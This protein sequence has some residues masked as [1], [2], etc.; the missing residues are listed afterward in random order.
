MLV[1]K[2][3]GGAGIDHE[4]VFRNV[5]WLEAPAIDMSVG[6]VASPTPAADPMRQR[7]ICP[8]AQ[9]QPLINCASQSFSRHRWTHAS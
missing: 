6:E 7:Q 4:A 2:I 3:G 1:I 8:S 5:K 9:S